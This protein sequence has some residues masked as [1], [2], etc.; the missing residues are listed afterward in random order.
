MVIKLNQMCHVCFDLQCFREIESYKKQE[1]A[2]RF[3]VARRLIDFIICA[4]RTHA[5]V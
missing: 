2:I 4:L 5:H 3:V 1:I